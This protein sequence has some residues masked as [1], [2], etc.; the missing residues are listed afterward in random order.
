MKSGLLSFVR[1]F[2]TINFYL[3]LFIIPVEIII[4]SSYLFD[5]NPEQVLYTT[6]QLG[7]PKPNQVPGKLEENQTYLLEPELASLQYRSGSALEHLFFTQIGR[8]GS[9]LGFD[10]ITPFF[11]IIL[12]WL[13]KKVLDSISSGNIFSAENAG[14]IKWMGYVLI[15]RFVYKL[16]LSFIMEKQLSGLN[17]PY[18]VVRGEMPNAYDLH[19]GILVLCIGLVY[20]KGVELKQEAELVV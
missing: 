12:L 6:V 3:S 11:L 20:Q 10:F 16:A 5:D 13:L 17:L 19:L 14:R 4:Y 8:S 18:S 2:V 9:A 7:S 1:W 15:G